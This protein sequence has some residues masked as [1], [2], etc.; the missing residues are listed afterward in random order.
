MPTTTRLDPSYREGVGERR[1]LATGRDV[2]AAW[3]TLMSRGTDP[4]RAYRK[5]DQKNDLQ[6]CR[7]LIRRS[8]LTPAML[9]PSERAEL[10]ALMQP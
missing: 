10:A 1:G 5:A 2:V 9:G 3:Q 7:E 8:G 4:A 6:R